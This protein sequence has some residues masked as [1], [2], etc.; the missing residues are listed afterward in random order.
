MPKETKIKMI[1]LN[2]ATSALKNPVKNVVSPFAYG[3]MT[4]YGMKFVAF[5]TGDQ[6]KDT[7]RFPM[8]MEDADIAKWFTRSHILSGAAIALILPSLLGKR[9]INAQRFADASFGYI[10]GKFVSENFGVKGS[11]RFTNPRDSL[12]WHEKFDEDVGRIS[13][14]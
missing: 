6:K 4:E 8:P 5:N 1:S 3:A 13:K 7:Y 12:K 9:N 2:K 11:P 10:G 14:Q